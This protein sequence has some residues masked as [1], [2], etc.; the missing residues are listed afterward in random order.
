MKDTWA[1]IPAD[2]CTTSTH[3]RTNRA[4]AKDGGGGNFHL[5]LWDKAWE[6]SGD[7]LAALRK[8]VRSHAAEVV[9]GENQSLSRHEK[10]FRRDS[11]LTKLQG[12]KTGVTDAPGS[13][14]DL[15]LWGLPVTRASYNYLEL[16]QDAPK[17]AR[18]AGLTESDIRLFEAKLDHPGDRESQMLQAYGRIIPENSL[19]AAEARIHERR[20]RIIEILQGWHKDWKRGPETAALHQWREQHP[21]REPDLGSAE[22]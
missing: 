8:S 5:G 13:S 18:K 7:P 6:G 19:K 22:A 14:D 20:P 1:V 12:A 4:L 17:A 11:P 9:R 3:L 2:Q 16:R 10:H 15:L 21:R